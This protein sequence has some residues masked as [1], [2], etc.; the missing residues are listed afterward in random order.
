MN[1]E[2]FVS[3]SGN[4]KVDITIHVDTTALAF[5][6]GSYLHALK[7]LDDDQYLLI[8]NNLHK[9]LGKEHGNTE[10]LLSNLT[11]SN[12]KTITTENSLKTLKKYY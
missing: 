7:Q 8:M 1:H 9:L 2:S 3:N 12:A 6:M 5:F 11:L 10:N 4:S